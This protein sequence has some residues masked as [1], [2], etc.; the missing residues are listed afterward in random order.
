[1]N[2]GKGTLSNSSR[3]WQKTTISLTKETRIFFESTKLSVTI[4]VLQTM[5]KNCERRTLYCKFV[6][7]LPTVTKWAG[8]ERSQ[9]FVPCY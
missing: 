5:D 4:C 1:V 2:G 6:R 3:Q 8:N 9:I 7:I